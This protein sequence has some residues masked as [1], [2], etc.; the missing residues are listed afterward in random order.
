MASTLHLVIPGLLETGR[1]EPANPALLI[2]V[3]PALG[4]L[5][6]R[7][8]VRV[9]PA[10]SDGVLFELFGLRIPETADLP[11][12]A[13]ARLANGG[14]PDDGWWLRADPVHLRPDLYGVLLADARVLAIEPV[15]AALLAA[16]FDQTF[17]A[18]GLQLCV[19]HPDRWYLR[20]PADPG[21]HTHPLLDAIGRDI[22][23]LLPHGP[24]C[25]RWHALLTE[26]QM[27]FHQHPIN[28]AREER[29]QP[30]INSVW[31]WGG[32]TCP[33][34]ARAPAADLYAGDPLA[35]GLARLAGAAVSP[36]PE[37]AGDWLDSA[38][39]EPDSLVVLE[40]TRY[41]AADGDRATWVE[42]V[43]ELEYAWFSFCRRWL[44][45][46]KLATLHL[47]PGNGRVYTVT[48]A[49]R[50]RFWRR[51]RPLVDYLR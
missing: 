8:N 36:V 47:Y 42:H 2:P 21:L 25:G 31:F 19:P 34:G 40:T 18:E 50:W 15:E 41:D 45:T 10:T 29:N 4:W 20:L 1:L 5:L 13:V 12:A 28:R 23:P 37:H 44:R 51:S 48:G 3:A 38:R 22:N 33:A 35:R 43:V 7:A 49:A 46:G 30:L 6:A 14:D 32:G 17:A 27:L 39:K 16:A 11:V 26:I 24:A 9:V